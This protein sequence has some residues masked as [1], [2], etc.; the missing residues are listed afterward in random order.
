MS[1]KAKKC[2]D[3][4]NSGFI[5]GGEAGIYCPCIVGTIKEL[6]NEWVTWPTLETI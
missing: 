5:G 1:K 4:N 3:C 6:E 2:L